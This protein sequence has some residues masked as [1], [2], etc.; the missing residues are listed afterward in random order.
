MKNILKFTIIILALTLGF[1]CSDR[2]QF[3]QTHNFAGAIWHRFDILAFDLPIKNPSAEYSVHVVMRYTDDLENDRIPMHFIMTMPSGEERIWEQTIVV[4]NKD[5]NHVGTRKDGIYELV[6]PVRSRLQS[7][8]EGFCHITAEQFIPKYDTQ[9][10]VS[11]G[12]RLIRN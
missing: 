10:I 7:T 4:R 6:V 9:G 2:K 11:F 8:Q 12:L 1:A 3:E 5:G